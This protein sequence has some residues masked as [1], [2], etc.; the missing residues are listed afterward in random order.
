MCVICGRQFIDSYEQQGYPEEIRRECLEMYVNGSGFRAIERVKKV[1]HTTIINW[2]KKA[3]KSL[4]NSP[5]YDEI[6][7]ITPD[8][9]RDVERGDWFAND[10]TLLANSLKSNLDGQSCEARN[11][12]AKIIS[13]GPPLP[14][15]NQIHSSSRNNML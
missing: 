7:E 5:D 14:N 3:G 10:M 2:V 15:P 9:S 4:P 13:L 8:F 11:T 1:H 12:L 6:P